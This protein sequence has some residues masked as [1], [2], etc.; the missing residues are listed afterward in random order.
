M[1]SECSLVTP[2]AAGGVVEGKMA[3]ASR[4]V[5]EEEGEGM[6]RLWSGGAPQVRDLTGWGRRTGDQV[7]MLVCGEL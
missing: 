1:P 3:E 7:L 6:D 5:E 2:V 4:F